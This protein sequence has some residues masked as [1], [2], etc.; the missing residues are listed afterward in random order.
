[1]TVSSTLRIA[2]RSLWRNVR[3]TGL[4]LAAISLSV[5]LVLAYTSILRAYSDWIVETMTGPT[6]GHVQAHAP[7]W[8]KDRQLEH[9]LRDATRI[10][11]AVRADPDVTGASARLYAPALAA[12]GEEGVAVMVLG[13]DTRLE[14][15]PARLLADIT[16]PLGDDAVFVGAQLAETMNLRDGDTL[17]VVGQAI[18]GSLAN[19]LFRVQRTVTTP[20]DLVNR[21]GIVM[22][23]TRAQALFAMPDE[24][25]EI[26]VHARRPDA[27]AALAARLRTLSPL[28]GAEVLD[29]RALAPDM[30]NIV[31][32]ADIAG[33][34]VLVLVFIA[35]AA[36]VA[37]TML[38]AT[39]ERTREFGMLLALGT[40]P[41]RI[42]RLVVTESIVLG[43]LG[44]LIGSAIGIALVAATHR[45]GID[46]ATL[47]GGG[48]SEL[49]FA[50]LRWS[51][52]FYPTLAAADVVRTVAAVCLTSLV[53]SIWPAARAGRLEPVRA[54]RG[55]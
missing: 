23:L 4:A 29:W 53:A 40:S 34:F 32:I 25:H 12:R 35:A 36:G 13:L 17:A 49:S 6:L 44:A 51:L 31:E 1:M 10:L 42:V 18:D 7:R 9:S 16:D 21:Q 41:G 45:S 55:T 14:S 33:V 50:G 27:A 48:P 3:R 20:V 39:F 19:D 22:N 46:Y 11:A 8:R 52:R 26:V 15:G 54:L 5:A 2:W 43:L 30:V 28:S 37:N 38:M 47:T 24:V